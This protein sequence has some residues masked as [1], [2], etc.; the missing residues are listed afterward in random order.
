[1]VVK[2]QHITNTY[3]FISEGI[4]IYL[5]VIPFLFYY[6]ETVPGWIYIALI[7]GIGLAFLVCTKFT[8][9]HLPA[10]IAIPIIIL[11]FILVGYSYTVSVVF[12]GLL[13]WRYITIRTK[14]LLNNEATYLVITFALTI[15][16]LLVIRDLEIIVFLI[17]QIFTIFLG[18]TISNLVMI[19]KEE[20][21]AFNRTI[22]LTWSGLFLLI[23]FV[24]YYLSNT[25]TKMMGAV[26]DIF[27]RALT[28]VV[29]VVAKGLEFLQF[30]LLVEKSQPSGDVPEEI[31]SSQEEMPINTYESGNFNLFLFIVTL[32]IIALFI[33]IIYRKLKHKADIVEQSEQEQTNK[34]EQLDKRRQFFRRIVNRR[35][36]KL[37]H[38]V[39]KLMYQLEKR[40]AKHQLGRRSYE[41]IEEWFTR[42]GVEG[43][44]IVYQKVRYGQ[45]D[46]TVEEVEQLKAV[47]R[48]LEQ[49]LKSVRKDLN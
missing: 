8:T 21:N 24:V 23:T 44:S 30:D 32:V 13:I 20:R 19:K 47:L 34:V 42:I 10:I 26:W 18:F 6:F 16:G 1:M 14:T 49:K 48:L 41:S 11:L 5:A 17:I 22:W 4:I 36:D 37:D 15:I 46:V 29:G 28:V 39:R 3:H 35:K 25:A 12:T 27:G 33:L 45:L 2:H 40:A 9:S 43:D 38:P 31:G 7:L